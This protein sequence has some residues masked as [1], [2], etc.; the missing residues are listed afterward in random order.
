[1]FVASAGRKPAATLRD[2]FPRVA[3]VHEWL[4]V[5]GGSEK[6]L[7]ALLDLFPYATL[8][9]SVY[10]PAPWPVAIT[11]R[12]VVTSFLNRLPRAKTLYPKLLPLMDQAFRSFDLRSFDLVISSNH[13]CAKNVRTPATLPHVCY[14]HTPMRYAWDP[15]FLDGE[16]LGFGAR[17]VFKA[18]APRL[19]RRDRAAAQAPDG[20]D[21][22][23]AN[24]SFVADRIRRYWGRESLVIHP[25]V[26]VTRFAAVLRRPGDYYLYLGRLVPYKRADLAAAA[27]AALDRPLKVVGA[28]RAA[29]AV[30]A[31]AGPQTE[32]LGQVSNDE[33]PALLA[34]ARALL[35]P[36]EEDFGI[37][38]VEA[39]AAGVPV[40]AYGFGGVRDSVVDG[41]TGVLFDEPTV[42]SLCAAI[43]RFEAIELRESD[44]RE[45]AAR[46]APDRFTSEFARVIETLTC[47]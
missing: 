11:G 14:C 16:R 22:V 41:V 23:I 24:S 20:P 7:L 19:R 8:F 6:V 44:L 30:R 17:L 43:E 34:G 32:F 36:G 21:V 33:L 2:R 13:A 31:A 10:D 9:T 5:P 28:G 42:A 26:D 35:F 4:T 15:A 18:W 1:V 37:V 46:F 29:E 38:P 39:Q 12:P 25:P 3:L 45:Q 27:C 47:R 40:I